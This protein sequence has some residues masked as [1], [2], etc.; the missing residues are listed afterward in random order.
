MA[1]ATSCPSEKELA[2]LKVGL[3]SSAELAALEPHVMGCA[4]CA[5]RLDTLVV[6]DTL[7]EA[8]VRPVDPGLAAPQ[9]A[10]K[11]AEIMRKLG[12][13]PQATSAETPT[14]VQQGSSFTLTQ[15][16]ETISR[17]DDEWKAFLAPPEQPGELG[18]LGGYRVLSILGEGGMGIVFEAEDTHLRRRVALKVIRPALAV[19]S[20][21]RAR[22]LRE[23]RAAAA[24]QHDNVVGVFQVGEV[25]GVPFIAMPLLAGET[26]ADRL[27]REAR[28]APEEVVRIGIET[29]A[30]LSAA[31][32]KGLVHRD[33]KPANIWLEVGSG[34]VKILDFGVVRTTDDQDTL[35]SAAD[36]VVGTP[37]YMAPEQA[38]AE[39]V[40]ARSDLFS[41]GAVLY[42]AISGKLPFSGKTYTAIL[43]NVL[44][45]RLGQ[46]DGR[47]LD[48]ASAKHCRGDDCRGH[49][50]SFQE[51]HRRC[52]RRD[53]AIERSDQH[54]GRSASL[55][56]F[57]G[58]ASGA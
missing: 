32:A 52:A 31:H 15:T 14:L 4:K 56:R 11:V 19:S 23:A 50:G 42:H 10:A 38:G 41:L 39:Q 5:A 37:A 51:D 45:H 36:T 20:K 21:I 2:R 43:A 25:R 13:H 1:Q 34:R 57:G 28:L 27:D 9:V 54:D 49:G 48:R 46:P 3:L 12:E 55:V 7:V 29:A 44:T 30:G 26:L 58:D 22:L 8:L 53:F 17:P 47:Q 6:S 24:V 35:I 33:L 18:R 40:D 16:V